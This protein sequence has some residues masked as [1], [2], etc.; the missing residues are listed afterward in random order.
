MG[1]E[2]GLLERIEVENGSDGIEEKMG[3]NKL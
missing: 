1:E 2:G 3:K